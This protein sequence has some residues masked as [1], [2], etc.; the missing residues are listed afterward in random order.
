MKKNEFIIGNYYTVYMEKF[1]SPKWYVT[2][3]SGLNV[4]DPQRL[5][6]GIIG[7]NPLDKRDYH[8]TNTP[9]IG[10]RDVRVSTQ[11]E[12]EWYNHSWKTQSFI[13][14]EDFMKTYSQ[15]YEIY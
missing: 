14:F 12:I 6:G 4:A 13:S 3:V 10:E 11:A 5:F 2:K 15:V 7:N 1:S 9:S 8:D